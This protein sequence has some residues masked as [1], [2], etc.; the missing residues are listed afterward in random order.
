M[1]L[2]IKN[3]VTVPSVN[4]NQ[5]AK[6]LRSVSASIHGAEITFS[7]VELENS[8][9]HEFTYTLIADTKDILALTSEM[10]REGA[11]AHGGG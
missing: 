11:Y 2:T 7:K 4:R 6:F 9:N 3:R 8:S 1:S 5:F 10:I